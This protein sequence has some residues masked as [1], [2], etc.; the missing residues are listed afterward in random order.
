MALRTLN[1]DQAHSNPLICHSRRSM[2]RHE[3]GCR[4][5]GRDKIHFIPGCAS[6]VSRG[7]WGWT[8]LPRTFGKGRVYCTPLC[9]KHTRISELVQINRCSSILPDFQEFGALYPEH[10]ADFGAV[11]LSS[12]WQPRVLGCCVG[13]D[14]IGVLVPRFRPA[15][16]GP[17]CSGSSSIATGTNAARTISTRKQRAC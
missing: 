11:E 7:C 10:P 3:T 5:T 13:G 2:P 15:E 8:L 14:K 16:I 6:S 9:A 4:K 17:L 1:G 12:L